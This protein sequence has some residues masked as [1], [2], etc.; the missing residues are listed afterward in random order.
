MKIGRIP[1]AAIVLV[2][3]GIAGFIIHQIYGA[4]DK[5]PKAY[6]DGALVGAMFVFLLYYLN[7]YLTAW[8]RSRKEEVAK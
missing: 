1:V 7:I 6:L 3:Y 5:L 8:I 2:I 4:S